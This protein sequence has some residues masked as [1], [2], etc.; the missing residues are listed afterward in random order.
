MMGL[1]DLIYSILEFL[2]F[3]YVAMV[4]TDEFII[5]SSNNQSSISSNSSIPNLLDEMAAAIKEDSKA[6]KKMT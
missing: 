2:S 6:C 4:D 5:P 1:M 3:R